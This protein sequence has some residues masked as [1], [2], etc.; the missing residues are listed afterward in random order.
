[1]LFS[2]LL[3]ITLASPTG[4]IEGHFVMPAN[5]KFSRPA[6]VVVFPHGYINVYMTELQKHL[7]GYWEDFKLAFIQDKQSYL[8]FRERAKQQAMD[9]ALSRMKRD[10]PI[11]VPDLT[12]TTSAGQFTFR[13]VPQGECEVVALVTIGNQEF[14]WSE[15]LILRDA[16]ATVT[17]Q[18]TNP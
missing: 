3:S 9:Y 8:L 10:N 14:V 17:L 15:A 6:Q 1:M 16:P 5:T 18:P 2:V 4:T 12:M 11:C 7:D 13:H